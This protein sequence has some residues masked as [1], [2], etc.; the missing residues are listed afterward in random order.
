MAPSLYLFGALGAS[1][2]MAGEE[3]GGERGREHKRA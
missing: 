3:G 1:W 2:P